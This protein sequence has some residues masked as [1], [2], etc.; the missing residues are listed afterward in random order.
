M[1]SFFKK[2]INTIKADSETKADSEIQFKTKENGHVNNS[3]LEMTSYNTS[4]HSSIFQSVQNESSITEPKTGS[5]ISSLSEL[6]FEILRHCTPIEQMS[7][8]AFKFLASNAEFKKYNLDQK[9]FSIGSNDKNNF[10]L[11]KGAIEVISHDDKKF[12]ITANTDKSK[13]IIAKLKPRS[14]GAIA[15]NNVLM[16]LI[17][18]DLLT[19]CLNLNLSCEEKT[20]DLGV[21]EIECFKILTETLFNE[22]TPIPITKGTKIIVQGKRGDYFYFINKGQFQ[23]KQR[24]TKQH[25]NSVVNI[26]EAGEYFGEEALI[27]G[28]KR[29]ATIVALTDGI[30][31]RINHLQFE[32]L[33]GCIP[34]VTLEHANE[35][36]E[37]G[38]IPLDVRNVKDIH[39]IGFEK[40]INIP[41]NLIHSKIFSLDMQASYL[42]YCNTGKI[43]KAAAF[44]MMKSGFENIFLLENGLSHNDENTN[45]YTFE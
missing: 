31:S 8:E 39:K 29:N 28:E 15:K 32:G 35:L 25:E 5:I 30:L 40:S 45:E 4:S 2:N 34:K 23:V 44:L 24:V 38:S 22:Q 17:D 1:L 12:I 9:I 36:I 21:D 18:D 13:S 43:S 19:Y 27:T 41:I 42:I 26:L 10:F 33:V 20:K 11:L 14:Y 7:D 16:A 37:A 3:L 6:E